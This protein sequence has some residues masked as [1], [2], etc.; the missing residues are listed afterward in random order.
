ML[1]EA[2]CSIRVVARFRPFNDRERSEIVANQDKFKIIY[3][4]IDQV[5]IKTFDG[6]KSFRFD[7]IFPPESA[8]FELFVDSAK[9]TVVEAM[10][11]YNGTFFA[12]G[13]TF[14]MFF[15]LSHRENIVFVGQTGSGKSYSMFGPDI[16][17]EELQGIIPR[18]SKFIFSQIASNSNHVEFAVKCSFLEIY[19]EKI[20][21]LLNPKQTNL[22]IRES[23]T[24]GVYV[25]DA[26]ENSVT[27]EDEI[28]QLLKY[29]EMSRATS[30]TS[31]NAKS[32]RSH[33]VLTITIVQ[34]SPDGSINSG[35]LNL[36]D[37]AG[38]EKVKKT[39]ASG[40][41]LQE[42]KKINQ[43]LSALGMCIHALVEQE[44]HIPYRDS[45]LTRILQESIG[46]NCKT[47]LL[48][49]A[50]PHPFNS[51][52]TISTLMFAQRAKS[53][54][55]KVKC[56][57][58]LSISELNRK[59][60]GVQ[61]EIQRLIAENKGLNFKILWMRANDGK[62]SG[63]N[64]LPPE[65]EAEFTRIMKLAGE[66]ERSKNNRN[67]DEINAESDADEERRTLGNETNSDGRSQGS[68]ID[69]RRKSNNLT[70][71]PSYL[72]FDSGA[73]GGTRAN[74]LFSLAEAKAETEMCIKRAISEISALKGEIETELMRQGRLETL[75]ELYK[76]KATWY[77]NRVDEANKQVDQKQ[78]LVDQLEKE[79][80][81]RNSIIDDYSSQFEQL[82]KIKRALNSAGLLT[83][84]Q[85]MQ[86]QQQNKANQSNQ[87]NIPVAGKSSTQ[88]LHSFTEPVITPNPSPNT[89]QLQGSQ[90][91]DAE[92]P[93]K[94]SPQQKR[95]AI[96][97]Q[98]LL[99][100]SEQTKKLK[101]LLEQ[102]QQKKYDAQGKGDSN[103]NNVKEVG[104]KTDKNILLNELDQMDIIHR[105]EEEEMKTD[106]EIIE[107]QRKL[108][109]LENEGLQNKLKLVQI[110]KEIDETESRKDELS[111]E[112]IRIQEWKRRINA[113]FEDAVAKL[114]TNRISAI[115]T[116]KRQKQSLDRQR[117]EQAIARELDSAREVCESLNKELNEA[118]AL[119]QWMSQSVQKRVSE[120]QAEIKDEEERKKKIQKNLTENQKNEK[121][122]AEEHDGIIEAVLESLSDH[123]VP[124]DI[125]DANPSSEQDK[126]L[127]NEV[128]KRLLATIITRDEALDACKEEQEAILKDIRLLLKKKKDLKD[129]MNHLQSFVDD[130]TQFEQLIEN[131]AKQLS[132]S[133]KR[134]A[135]IKQKVNKRMAEER[136]RRREII[137][138]QIQEQ[139]EQ[140]RLEEDED[141]DSLQKRNITMNQVILST[142]DRE[143][144]SDYEKIEIERQSRI[145]NLKNRLNERD[146]RIRTERSSLWH[147]Q[148]LAELR[149]KYQE[150]EEARNA[151]LKAA[152]E[153]AAKTA[154]EAQ[155][156]GSDGKSN[157]VALKK[158]HDAEANLKKVILE[159]QKQDQNDHSL[160]EKEESAIEQEFQRLLV[161]ASVPAPLMSLPGSHQIQFT[162][163]SQKIIPNQQPIGKSK[164]GKLQTNSETKGKKQIGI[165][166]TDKSQFNDALVQAEEDYIYDNLSDVENALEEENWIV[167]QEKIVSDCVS[168]LCNDLNEAQRL[169]QSTH[170]Y[171]DQHSNIIDIGLGKDIT[172]IQPTADSVNSANVKLGQSSIQQ[173]LKN[174]KLNNKTESSI[175]ELGIPSIDDDDDDDE[176]IISQ[177]ERIKNESIET[178]QLIKEMEEE[179]KNRMDEDECDETNIEQNQ[180]QLEQKKKQEQ[181]DMMK[182]K[183]EKQKSQIGEKESKQTA[184][185]SINASGEILKTPP[186]S[187]S[188]NQILQNDNINNE[189]KITSKNKR[190][191]IQKKKSTSAQN[192]EEYQALREVVKAFE[193][194][195]LALMRAHDRAVA[196]REQILA[197]IL[198][199]QK[200]ISDADEQKALVEIEI[201][202][203]KSDDWQNKMREVLERI[204]QKK[205]SIKTLQA[206]LKKLNEQLEK[207]EQSQEQYLEEKAKEIVT[208]PRVRMTATVN[209][210]SVL[211][212]IKRLSQKEFGQMQK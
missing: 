111:D 201:A 171:N 138:V 91:D 16:E 192:N 183:D 12:Y 136:R 180:N 22:Q 117:K 155:I 128:E 8:Q 66:A 114:A 101:Q 26:T 78:K 3:E 169:A 190:G 196:K 86:H 100:P 170:Q 140:N 32:S 172:N 151:E 124:S 102:L 87:I 81:E 63:K 43:S 84:T 48:V 157:P 41:T 62:W 69:E 23:P 21:D 197:K 95:E 76:K 34:T 193:R 14:T 49:C 187:P 45:K 28:S 142:E 178:E 75:I 200:I 74:Q 113:N 72:A 203:I 104:Q 132:Q 208:I 77:E 79:E 110:Q 10:K 82:Q 133:N 118:V 6:Q 176:Q 108:K 47:T 149:K 94:L 145:S 39:N 60:E 97:K 83:P 202:E 148:M 7:R 206:T 162:Q 199:A 181:I 112:I 29:G 146:E 61:R 179:L 212:A 73:F 135:E 92:I 125:A 141:N 65:I 51:D 154:I 50:S 9:A 67:D 120:R 116:S 131:R 152:E 38:S 139:E 55:N 115:A 159:K 210:N 194:Q 4:G 103:N 129:K 18:A 36:V 25:G 64:P 211:G 182:K 88:P 20:R 5:T 185:Q 93:I 71:L 89:P 191:S 158:A 80:Q 99:Q 24:I 166:D 150:R 134:V 90:N 107:I 35:K 52:E 56:N 57:T 2:E 40:Q 59:I 188:I 163:I 173:S 160:L 96:K 27:Q 42:A 46:G 15:Y 198:K 168:S 105:G 186:S 164:S 11:G 153:V 122:R 70:P 31:M 184:I 19:N 189:Q 207:Q 195:E 123:K 161:A 156:I 13:L 17:S 109:E 30:F 209:Q 165:I 98:Q 167:D 175:I 1:D 144:L 37:L 33:S 85:Y 126:K 130:S 44:S 68:S 147:I 58:Q 119:K 205:F 137:Q 54:K 174:A 106:S 127:Q 143:Q 121:H 204:D 177:L 53:I